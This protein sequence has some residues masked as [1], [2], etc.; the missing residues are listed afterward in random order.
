MVNL[1][2]DFPY[3]NH[4]SMVIHRFL[5][6]AFQV[7]GPQIFIRS[8]AWRHGAT[9]GRYYI[10][11]HTN[12]VYIYMIYTYIYIYDIYIYIY[13]Y[14]IYMLYIYMIYTYIYVIYIYVYIWN[15]HIY[16]YMIYTYIQMMCI[17]I[18][19]YIQMMCIYICVY[20]TIYNHKEYIHIC[21]HIII[22]I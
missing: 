9:K 12:D 20:T 16:I 17:Y 6:C 4:I 15:I 14:M 10:Y 13:I 11:T 5:L 22:Y 18:Y 21:D 2:D 19:I 7:R 3:K 8:H 1:G